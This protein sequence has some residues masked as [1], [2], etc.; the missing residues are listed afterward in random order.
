MTIYIIYDHDEYGPEHTMA[1]TD[2]DAVLPMI[3]EWLSTH[4]P[5]RFGKLSDE[6]GA[7][8]IARA[9][10]GLASGEAEVSI[11]PGWGGLCLQVVQE[12]TVKAE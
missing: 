10:E 5:A 9:R 4:Y 8:M 11:D 1:T 3:E 12:F 7:E 6:E 2:H